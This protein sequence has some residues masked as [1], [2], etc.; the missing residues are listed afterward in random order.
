MKLRLDGQQ[1]HRSDDCTRGQAGVTG[2]SAENTAQGACPPT[3]PGVMCRPLL[4]ALCYGPGTEW[5]EVGD[6]CQQFQVLADYGPLKARRRP[7][8]AH[9]LRMLHGPADIFG[10]GNQGGL[11]GGGMVGLGPGQLCRVAMERR[12]GVEKREAFSLFRGVLC[13]GVWVDEKG[14]GRSSEFHTNLLR[15]SGKTGLALLD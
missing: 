11:S 8:E 15:I 10:W 4:R 2:P 3:S 13:T 9:V 7:R 6:T 1:G 12:T 14:E 5:V